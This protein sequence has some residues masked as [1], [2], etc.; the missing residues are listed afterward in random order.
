MQAKACIRFLRLQIF[1]LS[2]FRLLPDAIFRISPFLLSFRLFSQSLPCFFVHFPVCS[3]DGPQT[4]PVRSPALFNRNFRIV[5]IGVCY[6]I[7][8]LL[9]PKG[10][11][12]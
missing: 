11:G 4:F 2:L 12:D 9:Y 5:P 6:Y 8:A 10:R 3:G 7:V 1:S